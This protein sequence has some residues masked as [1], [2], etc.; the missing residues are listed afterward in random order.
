MSGSSGRP[1]QAITCEVLGAAAGQSTH[2]DNINMNNNHSNINN[3]SRAIAESSSGCGCNMRPRRSS[4]PSS[5][6]ARR[7]GY[8]RPGYQKWATLRLHATVHQACIGGASWG[9]HIC[10]AMPLIEAGRSRRIAGARVLGRPGRQGS[11]AGPYPA[12]RL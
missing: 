2:N 3:D 12:A 11:R 5:E 7:P 8:H 1:P 9:T 10:I 6:S 4:Q